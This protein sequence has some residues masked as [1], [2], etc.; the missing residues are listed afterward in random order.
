MRT[1]MPQ[2]KSLLLVPM[3][4][5]LAVGTSSLASAQTTIASTE[6]AAADLRAAR[7]ALEKYSDPLLAIKD[8]YLSTMACIDFPN[9]AKD[10][11]IDYPP[12]AMGV[13]FL[14]AANIGPKLDP[15]KP[16]VLIYEPHG[17]KLVLAAAE[18]FM[19]AQIV[20][21]TKPAIFGH[22]LVGPMDG[23]EPIMPPSLRH[24]DLH[25]WLWKNNPKGMF[26]STNSNMKCPSAAPYTVA[27]G[28]H[29]H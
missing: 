9:G 26:V 15:M 29:H 6:P 4:M 19:P 20:G 22:Q 28:M 14:N 27:I 7:A 13:H 10:G 24:Y 1:I 3:L 17:N 21:D 8:G 16:Q 2:R 5:A 18:W 25:V 11:P 23:H 12:G